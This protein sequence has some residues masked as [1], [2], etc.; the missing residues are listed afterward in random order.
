VGAVL[1]PHIARINQ[2]Q[3][4]LIHQSRGLQ[5]VA[6]MFP[7]HVAMRQPAKFLVNQRDQLVEG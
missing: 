3:V 5:R 1:P 6:G 4:S 2:A 7:A